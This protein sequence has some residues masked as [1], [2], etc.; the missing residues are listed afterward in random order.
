MKDLEFNAANNMIKCM[1]E[2]YLKSTKSI[3]N[4]ESGA[5]AI[6]SEDLHKLGNY[7]SRRNPQ[8]LQEEVIFL[9][10]YHFAYRGREWMRNLDKESLVFSKDGNGKEF[11]VFNKT[12]EE[13]N[14]KPTLRKRNYENI[15]DIVM[16]A[17]PENKD[18]CPVEALRLYLSKIPRDCNCLFPRSLTKTRLK[19]DD[20]EKEPVWY[21]DKQVV[22]K[23]VLND[24][25]KIISKKA[26][27]SATYTNHC[28][29]AT[30]VSEMFSKGYTTDQIQ[31]VTGHKRSDSVQRYIKRVTPSKKRKISHDLSSS[32]HK[33]ENCENIITD[34][35]PEPSTSATISA[36]IFPMRCISESTSESTYRTTETPSQSQHH[37]W[38]IS[39]TKTTT[40]LRHPTSVLRK[41]GYVL[42]FYLD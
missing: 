13:K 18:K 6:D 7:F 30:V 39:G 10:I 33:T 14:V 19:D 17:T 37:S 11:V 27:L 15:K 40:V 24:A 31:T 28:I 41:N 16:Y 38:S 5:K 4:N 8:I 2:K 29:R 3:N 36:E 32:I 20:W 23:H 21:S 26:G 34:N 1:I 9:I 22:G 35:I 12:L 25:M 42:E